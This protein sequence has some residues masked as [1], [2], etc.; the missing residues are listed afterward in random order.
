MSNILGWQSC[1]EGVGFF[2]T[3]LLKHTN[4]TLSK[5]TNNTDIQRINKI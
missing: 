5:Q 1:Y 3:I 4:N 2:Y